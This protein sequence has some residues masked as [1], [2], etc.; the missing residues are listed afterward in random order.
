MSETPQTLF[1]ELA[2]DYENLREELAWDPFVHI[3]KAFEGRILKGLKI[4]D[5]GCGTGE[6]TRW[7]QKQGAEPYGLD[8]SPAMCYLA[9]ERSENI[10]YLNH[11][12]S[13]T[14]PFESGRFD[15]VVALGCLEYVENIEDTVRE[16]RRVLR[17][18]GIFLGCFERYGEDCPNGEEKSVVFFDEWIR[19]R[20]SE[21]QIREMLERYFDEISLERVHGFKLTDDDGNETGEYTQY[22]RAIAK[23]K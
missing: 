22:I 13:E 1:D 4:L 16:F 12:L 8:I 10:P 20:Q 18:G 15:G 14:L 17:S 11:D 23:V 9:A 21:S 7:F 5:A 3:Q 6:C 19:Y 2:E